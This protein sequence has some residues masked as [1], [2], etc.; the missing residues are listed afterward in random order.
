MLDIDLFCIWEH[1]ID[2]LLSLIFLG[3]SLLKH[4]LI[5]MRVSG[6]AYT[7]PKFITGSCIP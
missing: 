4:T 2:E 3:V 1:S 7:C 6:N 5:S